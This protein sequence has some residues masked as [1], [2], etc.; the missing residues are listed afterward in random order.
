MSNYL[1]E[2]IL[3]AELE[4]DNESK[5]KLQEDICKT[6]LNIW[7]RRRKLPPNYI[8]LGN[9]SNLIDVIKSFDNQK[10]DDSTPYWRRFEEYEVK[11]SWGKY[12]STLR[13]S[14]EQSLE[15]AI[16]LVVNKEL[17]IKE[18]E[19]KNHQQLLDKEEKEII[20]LIDSLIEGNSTTALYRIIIKHSEEEE[21]EN[22][23][24]R[25]D[26]AFKMLHKLH[27]DQGKAL[28]SFEKHF[29]KK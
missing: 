8:P 7:E 15:L 18:L 4:K 19:W 9:L 14:V 27:E 22:D 16:R 3:K 28:E 21:K 26:K 6:I 29:N 24:S 17:L 11:N 25:I 23:E 1:A 12:L 10:G 13:N 5:L 20:D 2:N